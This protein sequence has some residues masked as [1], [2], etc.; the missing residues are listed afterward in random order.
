LEPG[1]EKLMERTT[2]LVGLA[3][4]VC[5]FALAWATVRHFTGLAEEQGWAL[6]IAIAVGAI[7]GVGYA[8]LESRLFDFG[9][10]GHR[11]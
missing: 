6:A 11:R 3:I 5:A 9:L 8:I 2:V 10:R 1:K 7:V 4:G